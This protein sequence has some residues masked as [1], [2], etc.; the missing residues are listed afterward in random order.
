MN[1]RVDITDKT[2]LSVNKRIIV[3]EKN[4]DDYISIPERS[5]HFKSLKD[6]KNYVIKENILFGLGSNQR[7][8]YFIFGIEHSY[9]FDINTKKYKMIYDCE[10][11]LFFTLDEYNE[12]S[13]WD[14]ST[15]D[16][17]MANEFRPLVTISFDYLTSLN[18]DKAKFNDNCDLNDYQ[19]DMLRLLGAEF[20]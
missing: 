10:G 8:F 5:M 19:K 16:V 20:I 1:I 14:Y 4:S 2:Y 13:I 6:I 9:G 15:F 7:L 11:N 17:D 3:F 12:F 18:V